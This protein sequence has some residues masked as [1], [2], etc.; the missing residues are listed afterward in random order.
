MAFFHGIQAI[1]LNPLKV[2]IL[3]SW[4]RNFLTIPVNQNKSFHNPLQ[5]D[6]LPS[7]FQHPANS[8]SVIV[9]SPENM[10]YEIKNQAWMNVSLLTQQ[11]LP[12]PFSCHQ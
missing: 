12:R 9:K 2:S 3:I 6:Y 10:N 11:F 4:K 7:A 8:N 5:Q 1:F